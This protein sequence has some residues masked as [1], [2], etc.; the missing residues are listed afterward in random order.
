M[1]EQWDDFKTAK[2]I[3]SLTDVSAV[4]L[5]EPSEGDLERVTKAYRECREENQ[6]LKESNETLNKMLASSGLSDENHR[7]HKA[8][9]VMRGALKYHHEV[10]GNAELYCM[11]ECNSLCMALSEAEKILGEK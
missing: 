6:R 3:K 8:V 11:A 4:N 5:S 2:R 10:W 1:S 9:E 7:L